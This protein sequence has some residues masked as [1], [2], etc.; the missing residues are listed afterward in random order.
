VRDNAGRSLLR[1]V[2][3]PFTS[4]VT[5]VIGVR[6]GN[7]RPLLAVLSGEDS[8]TAALRWHDRARCAEVDPEIFFPEKGQSQR[9]ARRICAA[10]PVREPCLEYALETSQAH[11]IWGGTGEGERRRIKRQRQE[12]E[13]AA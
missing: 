12:G 6:D 1:A 9:A 3:S 2:A 8:M 11:G 7:V 13:K 10:C 4:D 5:A